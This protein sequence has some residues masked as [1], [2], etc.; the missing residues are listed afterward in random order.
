MAK[1]LQKCESGVPE[2]IVS[3]TDLTMAETQQKPSTL[4]LEIPEGNSNIHPNTGLRKSW[5]VGCTQSLE[6]TSGM[7]Y[8]GREHPSGALDDVEFEGD[9]FDD[10]FDACCGRENDNDDHVYMSYYGG[11]AYY[12]DSEAVYSDEEGDSFDGE[13]DDDEDDFMYMRRPRRGANSDSGTEGS[14]GSCEPPKDLKENKE[15]FDAS[16]Y[17]IDAHALHGKLARLQ[18]QSCT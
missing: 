5:S 15:H 6:H 13:D 14:T 11:Q 17:P 1:S 4:F 16:N 12:A 8:D 18:I 2:T 9:Y 7:W 3:T 10:E